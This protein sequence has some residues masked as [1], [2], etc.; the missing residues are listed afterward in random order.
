MTSVPHT[1]QTVPI[2][3]I[4]EPNGNGKPFQQG[5]SP[6]CESHP[7]HEDGWGVLRTTAIQPGIFWDYENKSL[8]E[9]L[10]PRPNIEVKP[11]DLLMTC[12]G[13]RSRC[14]I[15]CLVER[16][17]PKL[18]LSGKMYRFRPNIDVMNPRFLTYFIQSRKAQLAI[19]AMKTGISDSGLNLTHDRFSGLNIPLAPRA[20]QERIVARIEE[21]FSEIDKG[22][23][24]LR[25]AKELIKSYRHALLKHAFE[26]E[27]TADWRGKHSDELETPN[28]ILARIRDER[29][30]R[31]TAAM[32]EWE[33]DVAK[34]RAA[35]E[36]GGR[37]SKPERILDQPDVALEELNLLPSLPPSWTWIRLGELFSLSPQNGLYKPASSYGTGTPIIRI[38][39]FYDGELIP[40]AEFKRLAITPDEIEKYLVE[41]GDLL[42]N[43]VN[44]IEY[45]GKCA[46]VSSLKEK[47]VFESNIMKL[48]VLDWAIEKTFVTSYLSSH[49]GR[50]RL[51]RNA[52]HA[53][54][55]ASINQAD[56]AFTP[57]P[58]PTLAEQREISNIVDR[59]LTQA[60]MLTSELDYQSRR[61]EALRQSILTNAFSG[62]L[63]AQDPNDESASV[64]LNRIRTKT[65]NDGSGGKKNNKNN[66]KKEAA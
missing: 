5:W 56:V 31:Y 66:G 9:D 50:M 40:D 47:S 55:Q 19:D 59:V 27:L 20:E 49:S 38:D 45:L 7:A 36:V 10:E 42:I 43:R 28:K 17:R 21:L 18:M 11:G 63:V 35:G 51:C 26:G 48:S 39:S 29:A 58:L 15:I 60:A 22:V 2:V 23:E 37:P 57:V 52:K 46:L 12:A 61:A 33:L 65:G 64:L 30:A 8:P 25:T 14:G 1:W 54:N 3:D 6:Q 62:Q 13:P 53:V 44:S 32:D 24:S 41:V 4:L 16:T 34:W